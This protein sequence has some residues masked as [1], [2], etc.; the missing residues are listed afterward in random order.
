MYLLTPDGVLASSWAACVC[1][2]PENWLICHALC[3][4]AGGVLGIACLNHAAGT[5]LIW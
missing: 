5:V 4:T 3:R 1:E 2:N